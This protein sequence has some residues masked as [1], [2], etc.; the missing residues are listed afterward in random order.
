MSNHK[1]ASFEAPDPWRQHHTRY[2]AEKKA[3]PNETAAQAIATE[4]E[5]LKSS[6]FSAYQCIHCTMW[7]VGNER[8]PRRLYDRE[9]I[10]FELECGVRAAAHLK[11]EVLSPLSIIKRRWETGRRI[12]N[13]ENASK[14]LNSFPEGNLN[15]LVGRTNGCS[16]SV[17]LRE[18]AFPFVHTESIGGEH[19]FD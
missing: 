10:D 11:E 15:V 8:K 7:H 13:R 4:M 5:E 3:Y 1:R 12:L 14:R 2:G 19:T 9:L 18:F 17:G 16:Q 6:P